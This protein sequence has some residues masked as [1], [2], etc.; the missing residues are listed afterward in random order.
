MDAELEGRADAT[1][2]PELSQVFHRRARLAMLAG[3]DALD[4]APAGSLGKGLTPEVVH[5]ALSLA[6][7]RFVVLSLGRARGLFTRDEDFASGRLFALRDPRLDTRVAI[8]DGA[9]CWAFPLA[10]AAAQSAFVAEL[11][12]G[13]KS[14]G[15]DLRTCPAELIGNLYELLLGEG[16]QQSEEGKFGLSSG[17]RRKQT[18]TFFTPRALTEVVVSRALKPLER[19]IAGS[20]HRTHDFVI[21]FRVCDPAVGGGAFLLEVMRALARRGG[22]PGAQSAAERRGALV[23]SVVHG[24]DI[25]P[26]AVAVAEA[27]LCLFAEDPGLTLKE[28]GK[29]LR[30]GDALL[31]APYGSVGAGEQRSLPFEGHQGLDFGLEFPEVFERGGFDLVIGNPPWVAYAGRAAQPLAPGRKA[32]FA[33]HYATLRGYPT[34]QGLFVERALRL[35]PQGTV[36]LVVP[37][38]LA[39]LHGYRAVRRAVRGSHTPCEPMLEFGQDA[40]LSVTQPCFALIAEASTGTAPP[41]TL[42]EQPFRL[43]E[44]QRAGGLAAEVLPPRALLEIAKGQTFPREL[45]GEMGFQTTSAVTQHLLRRSPTPDLVHHYPLLEGR[46]VREFSEGEPRLFLSPDPNLLA[47]ARCRLRDKNDYLRVRFVI[48]QTARYPIAALHRGLPFRNSLLAGF[49]VEGFPADLV[50]GLLNSSL[51][52]ALHLALRRD[53]RQATFPQVKIGHLR[54]L[55]EPPL[56]PD[57]RAQI[58]ELSADL[59]RRGF[60]RVL[61]E[62]LDCAVFGLFSLESSAVHEILTFLA[63]RGVRRQ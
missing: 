56:D 20:A 60:D 33:T 28:A 38:P 30:V 41:G 14:D 32:F 61:A 49:A 55:P 22:G 26:V 62:R 48:R 1:R 5:Q 44:R 58:A 11:E 10:L 54:A 21:E 46:D 18:G 63:A 40:F 47:K 51:Y 3:L 35:A 43:A 29:N 42:A 13:P 57:L 45:F 59:T 36:A 6:V 12:V 25:N 23:T 39:D 7:L 34:L 17:K 50:V 27:A 9:P 24:V 2:D 31:G 8:R 52:R 37:S 19:R 16:V 53:A 15:V 4:R